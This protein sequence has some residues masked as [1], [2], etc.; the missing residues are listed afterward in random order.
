M[1]GR[2]FA[3]VILCLLIIAIFICA[4]LNLGNPSSTA[5]TTATSSLHLVQ[6]RKY[7]HTIFLSPLSSFGDLFPV[8]E[9][10]PLSHHRTVGCPITTR[11]HLYYEKYYD[12]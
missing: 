11:S 6:P 12:A 1:A 8:V 3:I 2:R 10:A 4:H 5:T 9:F 7:K